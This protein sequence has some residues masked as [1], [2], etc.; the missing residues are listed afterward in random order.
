MSDEKIART[1]TTKMPDKPGAFMLACKVIMKHNG[2]IIRVSFNRGV[3]LFIEVLATREE[4]N[5]IDKE[6]SEI[7][8]V[9]YLPKEP[10]ILVM[11]VRIDD[12]PGALYPVLQ[13]INKYKVNISYLNSVAENKGF[14]NFNIGMEV[15]NPDTSKKILDEIAKLYPLDVISYNGNNELLDVTVKYIRLSNIIRKLFSLPDEK[16]S[17][18]IKE[19]KEITKILINHKENPK[20]VFDEVEK[21]VNFIAFHK[22]LNFKPKIS[23]IE[24]TKETDLFVIEPP[25]GSNTYILKNNDSLLFIDTGL[26]IYSDE[27][28]TE[29]RE[30]L[31]CF[32]SMEKTILVTH[33]DVDHCGLLSV[34]ENAKI[35]M[36]ENTSKLLSKITNDEECIKDYDAFSYGYERLSRIISDYMPPNKNMIQIIGKSPKTINDVAL[37]GSLKFVDINFEIYEGSGGHLKGETILISKNPKIIFTG[38]VFSNLKELNENMTELDNVAPYLLSNANTDEKKLK[39]TRDKLKEIVKA[40]GKTGTIVC[41]GHGAIKKV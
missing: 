23:K 6:L 13:I 1:F 31:P 34:I 20:K 26:G 41:G 32:F 10:T 16:V 36:S 39:I 14:Q 40:A 29:L 5:A 27:M 15:E 9:D 3:N 35:L 37:V 8:Y 19:S 38:D 28:I 30:M 33:A 21:L 25:C 7:S 17:E 22:D 24:L 4:L 18:L 11:S 12:V 2:N